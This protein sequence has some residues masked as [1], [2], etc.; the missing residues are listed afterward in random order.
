MYSR[1]RLTAAF[2]ALCLLLSFAAYAAP[3]GA[4]PASHEYVLNSPDFTTNYQFVFTG[5]TDY[6]LTATDSRMMIKQ[7]TQSP[8]GGGYSLA[9]IETVGALADITQGTVIRYNAAVIYMRMPQN[10]I[11]GTFAY[12]GS[13][14]KTSGHSV[15]IEAV[16]Y[17]YYNRLSLWVPATGEAYSESTGAI[18]DADGAANNV[19]F[20]INE[21]ISGGLPGYNTNTDKLLILFYVKVSSGETTHVKHGPFAI[22]LQPGAID[23]AP[24]NQPDTSVSQ[25]AGVITEKPVEVEE[26]PVPGAG[27]SSWAEQSVKN[28]IEK[29][30]L[31]PPVAVEL[32]KNIARDEFVAMVVAAWE[33]A[34]GTYLETGF[35]PFEDL[36]A[37]LYAETIAKVYT[38]SVINGISET[39]FNPDGFITR[40]EAAAIIS[41]L[42]HTKTGEVAPEVTETTFAD[43]AQI[44]PWAKTHVSFVNDKQIML[45]VGDN[46]FSPTAIMTREQSAVII[47]RVLAILSGETNVATDNTD[48]TSEAP[49]EAGEP[50]ANTGEETSA[51]DTEDTPPVH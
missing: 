22:E 12:S 20:S 9:D 3:A 6:D 7:G 14:F 18:A 31:P 36:D 27:A 24:A 45:G 32:Q 48:N 21:M 23:A 38:L 41:R 25:S 46:T 13:S 1:H 35:T 5:I 37:S 42:I 8:L 39:A 33:H 26:S 47:D 49:P 11:L 28:L 2:A 29:D 50:P 43:D 16:P 4:S 44:S 15:T 10:G 30:I 51:G 40:Q 17:I 19:S 34:T